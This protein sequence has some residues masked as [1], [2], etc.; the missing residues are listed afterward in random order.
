MRAS[1]MGDYLFRAGALEGARLCGADS[2]NGMRTGLA[3]CRCQ[4]SASA[5]S[6]AD[7][8]SPSGSMIRSLKNP[9]SGSHSETPPSTCPPT[10]L[11]IVRNCVK[12]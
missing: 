3:L 12:V 1:L 5:R 11:A 8:F 4:D 2:D 7:R 6:V 9:L 10:A